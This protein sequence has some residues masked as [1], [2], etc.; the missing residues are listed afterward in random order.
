M[1]KAF[2]FVL[3]LLILSS[4]LTYGQIVTA[5]SGNWSDAAT[6]TGGVVPGLNDNVVITDNDTV[7]IDAPSISMN[8]LTVGQGTSGSLRFKSSTAVV[9]T[10]SGS[11][12]ISANGEFKVLTN[13]IS[14]PGLVDTLYLYGDLTNNGTMDFRTGSAGST[15]SVC[16]LV[17]TGTTNS[18]LTTPVKYQSQ[19]DFNKLFIN[20]SNKAKVI[21]GS[22]IF[23]NGGSSTAPLAQSGIVFINGI[24][25]TGNY[26]LVYVGTTETNISGYS[27]SS[28]V[29]GAMGRGISNSGPSSKNFPIGDSKSYELITVHGTSSG[30][31]TG[32]YALVR[33]ITGDANTGSSILNGGIDK[34]SQVRYYQVGY[35]VVNGVNTP[36]AALN[37]SFDFFKVSYNSDDGVNGGNTD[38]RMAI[39]TDNRATWTALPQ[40]YDYTT[41]SDTLP[42]QLIDTLAAAITVNHGEDPI[43]IALARLSG[44]TTNDLGN[45]AAINEKNNLKPIAYNL[46]QSYP[47]PFNPA[48]TIS[49]SIPQSG[50]VKLSVY[51]VLGKE[52]ATLV[53]G[54]VSA[55]VHEVNFKASNIASGIYLYTIK[56][57]N[58]SKT[59]KM[60][61]MK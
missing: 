21:L 11:I 9:M 26:A 45:P 41:K 35:H 36:P 37:M 42:R 4:A 14:S 15:L 5:A 54:Y 25:E 55:G 20:K 28:Y 1:K 51:N 13:T 40:N 8:N 61:L 39:S 19:G 12:T 43:F 22:D 47:N 17:L 16:D 2:Y 57:G 34:V 56:A 44:T 33:C 6:W 3:G 59:M 60:I 32:H 48:T 31:S 29:I 23:V 52:V 46:S 50:N 18:T 58:F 10:V 27:D 30:G 49:Y 24:V 7:I 38:L 53:N